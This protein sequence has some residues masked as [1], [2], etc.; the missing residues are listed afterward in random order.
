MLGAKAILYACRKA[1]KSRVARARASTHM[2]RG[3]NRKPL[4]RDLDDRRWPTRFCCLFRAPA[5]IALGL[6]DHGGS[7]NFILVP[8]SRP[9]PQP[10]RWRGVCRCIGRGRPCPRASRRGSAWRSSA[11]RRRT[12]RRNRR[13][14]GRRIGAAAVRQRRQAD[15]ASEGRPAPQT[16]ARPWEW[17][18]FFDDPELGTPAI[19]DSCRTDQRAWDA[20]SMGPGFPLIRHNV[21]DLQSDGRSARMRQQASPVRPRNRLFRPR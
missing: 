9:S 1:Q 8:A 16:G 7:A 13:W 14:A 2:S 5:G 21:V 20:L 17:D 19:E 12:T 4:S 10:T 3:A 6:L 15:A 11:H 18:N